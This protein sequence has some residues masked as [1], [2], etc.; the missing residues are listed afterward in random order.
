MGRPRIVIEV[1][2]RRREDR[3]DALWERAILILCLGA[4]VLLAVLP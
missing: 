3:W 1:C 2:G 4:A